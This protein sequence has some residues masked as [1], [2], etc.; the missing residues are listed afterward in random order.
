MAD[1]LMGRK[2]KTRRVKEKHLLYSFQKVG[3]I[4]ALC[5]DISEKGGTTQDQ[6]MEILS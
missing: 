5:S 1:P 6:I 4:Y 3:A 2:Q